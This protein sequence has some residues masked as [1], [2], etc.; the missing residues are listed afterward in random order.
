M[1]M[2]VPR[3]RRAEPNWPVKRR[4]RPDRTTCS[5]ARILAA[6]PNIAVLV[7]TM[8]DE[9]ESVFAAMRAVPAATS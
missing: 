8:L 3:P 1:M 2:D 6:N 9:D 5:R 7:Q 4:V